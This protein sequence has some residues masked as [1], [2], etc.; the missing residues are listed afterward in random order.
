MRLA[1]FLKTAWPAGCAVFLL[2]AAVFLPS[3]GGDFLAWDDDVFIRDNILFRGFGW[4]RIRWM[5][6]TTYSGLYMPLTW[7]SYAVDH[8]LWGLDPAGY[9]LTNL[10]LHAANAVLLYLVALRLL[11]PGR[12]EEGDA[13]SAHAAAALAALLWSLHPLRVESVAWATERRDV[14]STL[15]FLGTILAYLKAQASGPGK[16]YY[17]RWLAAAAGTYVLS[18]LS[19]G[20][21]ITLPAVLLILDVYPLR[22]I[23]RPA[24]WLSPETRAVWTEKALFALPALL[25]AGVGIYAQREAGTIDYLV[26]DRTAAQAAAQALIGTAF[27]VKANL[28]PVGLL[29]LYE[30]RPVAPLG[31][32]SLA[33]AGLVGLATV[34]MI[35]LRRRWP[36]GLAG[37]AYYLITLAPVSGLVQYGPQAMADRYSYVPGL[38]W[39]LWIGGGV[40]WLGSASRAD[41]RPYRAAVALCGAAILVL[42]ALTVKQIRVW[43]DTETLWAHVLAGDP[44]SVVALVNLG[45]LLQAEGDAPGAERRFRRAAALSPGAAVPRLN[46]AS[47]LSAQGREREALAEL[48][49][50]TRLRPGFAKAHEEL[51]YARLRLGDEPGGIR[52]LLTA[53]RLRPH[54]H[55]HRDLG[56]LLSNR[57]RLAEAEVQFRKALALSPDLE[58]A[59]YGLA[60]IHVRAGRR[61]AAKAELRT[62][63]RL[64][65]SN[66]KARRLLGSLEGEA[67]RPQ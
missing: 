52:S 28:L 49:E 58:G 59:L 35:A 27:Y 33:S 23:P 15:F 26:R 64:Y 20:M 67:A 55:I 61:D 42:S 14:L 11:V 46:L 19:K 50:L 53:A 5:F 44:D 1:R 43:S 51:G 47:A 12:G 3:L 66:P 56:I 31:A 36:A 32:A 21:G 62:L 30:Q 18:L 13:S 41:R 40:L 29:P 6:T 45:T 34:L 8:A 24:R 9:H 60:L 48:D 4:S 57:D 16:A 38:A 22:R 2:T 25:A 37:W 10:L 54:A 39:P 65:P 63:L 7:L 17:R